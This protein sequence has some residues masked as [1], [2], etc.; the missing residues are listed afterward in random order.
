VCEFQAAGTPRQ[1]GLASCAY[2]RLALPMNMA[3]PAMRK[4]PAHRAA[5][6]IQE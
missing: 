3:W 1:E 2:V 5:A 4:V 6:M